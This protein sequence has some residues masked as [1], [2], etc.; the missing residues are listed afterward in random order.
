MSTYD[1]LNHSTW[2]CKYRIVFVPKGRNKEFY[3]KV[4][5]FLGPVFHEWTAY[6]RQGSSEC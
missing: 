5:R 3:G 1:S 2:D 4:R 6:K